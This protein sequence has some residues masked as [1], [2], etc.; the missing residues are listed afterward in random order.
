MPF[1]M[2][3]S[4]IIITRRQKDHPSTDVHSLTLHM[5]ETGTLRLPE[6]RLIGIEADDVDGYQ[7]ELHLKYMNSFAASRL[8][9]SSDQ[10]SSWLGLPSMKRVARSSSRVSG[11]RP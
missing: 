8:W 7:T 11:S 5:S 2:M 1:G 4:L 6:M 10:A 3:N 9:Q